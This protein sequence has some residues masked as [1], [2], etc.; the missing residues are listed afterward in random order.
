LL[1]YEANEIP[2]EFN[3]HAETH[4]A[5]FPS[6]EEE[7]GFYAYQEKS[8]K[9][10]SG[11]VTMKSNSEENHM[12]ESGFLFGQVEF[13]NMVDSPE[14]PMNSERKFD[15]FRL[16][17]DCFRGFSDYFKKK[18]KPFS[19][20]WQGGKRNKLKKV[21]MKPLIERFIRE[22]L[23]INGS[24]SHL[25]EP[26]IIVLHSHRYNKEEEFTVN[27]DFSIIRNLIQSYSQEAREQFMADNAMALFFDHFCLKGKS[28]FLSKSQGKSSSYV[29]EIQKE[30][31]CLH[32]EA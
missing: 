20:L 2:E 32:A 26:M 12:E 21:E 17:R 11:D 27:I 5:S 31:G 22:E 13:P 30:I 28:S 23:K 15:N 4:V 29:L 7:E 19:D 24:V 3:F 14:M 25:I 18:F 16:R 1:I 8:L 6:D 9:E 10:E